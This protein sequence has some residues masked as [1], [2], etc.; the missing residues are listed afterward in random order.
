MADALYVFSYDIAGNR[1]RRRVARILEE[2]CVR[3]QDSVFEARLS[4]VQAR[5]LARNAARELNEGDSLRVYA[6]GHGMLERCL[7]FGAPPLP[8]QHEFYLL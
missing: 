5:K 1:E 8:E 2:V 7:A 6:I 4:K 3:V